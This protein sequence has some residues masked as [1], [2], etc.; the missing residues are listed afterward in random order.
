MGLRNGRRGHHAGIA[1]FDLGVSASTPER[2]ANAGEAVC[3]SVVSTA[4]E[5]TTAIS[6]T[7]AAIAE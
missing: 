4:V 1:I 6:A 7:S 3:E 2:A 5:T